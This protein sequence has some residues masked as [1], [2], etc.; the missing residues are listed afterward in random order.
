MKLTTRKL[1][2]SAVMAALIFVFTFL[3]HIPVPGLA[4][5]YL[6]PGDS[7]IYL[8]GF[9]LGGI[10][11]MFAAGI[12][13]ALADLASNSTVYAPATLV[14]KGTMGLI[15]GYLMFKPSFSRFLF[16]SVLG[17]AI[18]VAGYGLYELFIFGLPYALTSLPFNCI[19]WVGGIIIAL[20]LYKPFTKM[21]RAFHFRKELER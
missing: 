19:Q 2:V 14:I 6:N 13:S 18:M 12:G 16:V 11:A 21:R 4:S 20:A 17:G 8:A 15:C 7:L 10:P 5:A 1:T 9:M 3:V